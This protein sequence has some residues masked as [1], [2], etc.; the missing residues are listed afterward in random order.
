MAK[1]RVFRAILKGADARGGAER[2]VAPGERGDGFAV[3][4]PTTKRTDIGPP[5]PIEPA[6]RPCGARSRHERVNREARL[7][8]WEKVKGPREAR[9]GRMHWSRRVKP[10]VGK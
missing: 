9:R 8:R 1:I 5:V 4:F 6:G 7:G 2:R 10:W 3:S